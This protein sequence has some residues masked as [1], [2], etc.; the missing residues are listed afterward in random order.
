MSKSDKSLLPF[1][2][3][4]KFIHSL[5]WSENIV[6]RYIVKV[7]NTRLKRFSGQSLFLLKLL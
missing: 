5:H 1:W 4:G 6:H 3:R 7:V 2:K